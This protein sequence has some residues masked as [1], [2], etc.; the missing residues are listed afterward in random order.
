MYDIKSDI[1][2]TP[3]NHSIKYAFVIIFTSL[4]LWIFDSQSGISLDMAQDDLESLAF[5]QRTKEE[6]PPTNWLYSL[7][8][9]LIGSNDSENLT[10]NGYITAII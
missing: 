3:Y 10:N 1:C 8:C 9:R 4:S 5:Y 2:G 6:N 7:G